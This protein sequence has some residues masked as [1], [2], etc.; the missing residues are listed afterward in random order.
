MGRVRQRG[1]TPEL[2]VR[3]VLRSLGVRYRLNAR[4]LPGSPD[5][6]NRARRFAIFVH[7]CYW[8]RHPDCRLTTTPTRNAAFWQ[9][10]FDA[11]QARD[12]RN[13]EALRQA[14]F[15]VLVVWE[16]ETRDPDRLRRLLK[17]FV[18]GT[19]ANLGGNEPSRSR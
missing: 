5:V 9:A 8:H 19:L 11:N 1:T 12:R 7:G 2:A 16:C 13:V 17:D 3:E 4:G 10:K 18:D 14:G 15:A 6:V